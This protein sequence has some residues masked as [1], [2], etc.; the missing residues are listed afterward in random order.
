[1]QAAR[2][3]KLAT[4][5]RG[6]HAMSATAAPTDQREKTKRSDAIATPVHTQGAQKRQAAA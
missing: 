5:F 2:N 6:L 1:M 4:Q 3:S